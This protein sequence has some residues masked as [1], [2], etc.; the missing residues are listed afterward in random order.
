MDKLNSYT[1][2]NAIPVKLIKHEQFYNWIKKHQ[3]IPPIH[4][5]L[6]PTN[7][8]NLNC[9][10]CSCKNDDRQSELSLEDIT[11]I[12]DILFPLGMDAVTISGGG[13]PLLHPNI[14][15]IIDILTEV[16]EVGLVT[17]GYL[18]KNL[19]N[20]SL[21]DITWCRISVSDD[22]SMD[23]I[24]LIKAITETIKRTRKIEEEIDWAF[25]YVVTKDFNFK[26]LLGCIEFANYFDFTHVRI[27]S[28]LL[29][30]DS[31][32]SMKEI[33]KQLIQKTNINLDKV[34]FQGRK[35][36]TYGAQK[37]YISLLKPVIDAKGD[38]YPC[39][40]VQYAAIIPDEFLSPAFKMGELKDLEYIM[41]EQR[42]F[43]GVDCYRCYYN[44]Y[45]IVLNNL[46]E[47]TEHVNFI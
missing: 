42:Y 40:G 33:K 35:E 17:N 38:I 29:D 19:S 43:D 16:C 21:M 32:L 7:K 37:C 15:G 2:A 1:A 45:N 8:C 18:L 34:I 14:N 28:D 22:S 24:H 12:R 25:S 10:W 11:Y 20:E 4:L 27:V 9:E 3:R 31:I 47:D 39:C 44:N 36:Y 46:L 30:L 26:R 13:E 5:Q 41:K 6:N 23:N